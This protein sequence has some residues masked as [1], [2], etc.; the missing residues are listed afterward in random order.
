MPEI[1]KE[2]KVIIRESFVEITGDFVKAV[3]LQQFFYWS[4]RVK[5]FDKFIIEER[6]RMLKEGTELNMPLQDG[7]IYKTAD[8]LSQETMLGLAPSNMRRHISKLIEKGFLDERC[9]PAHKWDRTKQYRINLVKIAQELH[10]LGYQLPGYKTLLGVEAISKLEN[11]FSKTKN[12]NTQIEKAIPETTTEIINS[13]SSDELGE[14]AKTYEDGGF[15]PI[16]AITGDIL[17]GMINDYSAAWVKD[18]ITVA[19]KS[20]K[21]NLR[22]VEGI[23]QNW[24]ANGRDAN[25]RGNKRN[26][27]KTPNSYDWSTEP[28]TL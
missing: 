11:A 7:W 23:L 14:I 24:K 5:D 16:T 21:R 15:G 8:E 27:G 20:G 6:G 28:D 22:Y 3:I 12:C 17:A 1:V 19:V 10:K 9:N 25:G 2:K 13:C 18:A 4:E 26:I